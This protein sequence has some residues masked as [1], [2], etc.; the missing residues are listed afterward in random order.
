MFCCVGIKGNEK[1]DSD[2]KATLDLPYIK[3]GVPYTDFNHHIDQYILS[4]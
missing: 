3:D 4:T 1:T 2:A